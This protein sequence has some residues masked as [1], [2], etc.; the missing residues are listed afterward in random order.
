MVKPFDDTTL[1]FSSVPSDDCLVCQLLGLPAELRNRLYRFALMED[2]DVSINDQSIP[3]GLGLLITCRQIKQEA[4][5]ICSR[6][7][8]QDRS[9]G[10]RFYLTP[11]VVPLRAS[12]PFTN[13]R[14]VEESFNWSNLMECI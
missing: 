13:R 1:A 6:K 12:P 5:T 10:I 11:E 3:E 9:S 8:I 4:L 14:E 2:G 7:F